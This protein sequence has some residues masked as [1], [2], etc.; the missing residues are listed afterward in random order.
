MQTQKIRPLMIL[1]T[2]ENANRNIQPQNN[3]S[4]SWPIRML[5]THKSVTICFFRFDSLY[6]F[7]FSVSFFL[8]FFFITIFVLIFLIEHVIS[9]CF[10]FLSSSSVIRLFHYFSLYLLSLDFSFAFFSCV[11]FG[12]F[13][14][15]IF[16]HVFYTKHFLFLINFHFISAF[17]FVYLFV[18]RI[19]MG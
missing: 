5:Y 8:S 13:D 18:W 15:C 4:H 2:D 17:W 19:E 12:V 7:R 9:L 10:I 3:R 11:R 1:T 14:H 6:I 16:V